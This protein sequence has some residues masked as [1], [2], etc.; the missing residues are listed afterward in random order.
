VSNVPVVRHGRKRISWPIAAT[1]ACALGALGAVIWIDSKRHA[2]DA[3]HGSIARGADPA[4]PPGSLVRARAPEPDRPALAREAVAPRADGRI[5]VAAEAEDVSYVEA[6]IDPLVGLGRQ[7]A[8]RLGWTHEPGIAEDVGT[9]IVRGAEERAAVGA[10]RP[11]D[12][13]ADA[14]NALL[15]R[16]LADLRDRIGETRA[17]QVVEKLRLARLDPDTGERVAIDVHGRPL[18]P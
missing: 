6:A 16:Q 4:L 17:A 8:E 10:G 15:E 9:W 2:G 14:H 13:A 1:S 11:G 18:A 7:L 12:L 3:A 5:P